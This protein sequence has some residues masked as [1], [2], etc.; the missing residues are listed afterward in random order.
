MDK[1][2]SRSSPAAG[3]RPAAEVSAGLNA[4]PSAAERTWTDERRAQL[5][6]LLGVGLSFGQAAK[7]L[8]V[9]RGSVCWA[10]ARYGI[11]REPDDTIQPE[12]RRHARDDRWDDSKLIERWAGRRKAA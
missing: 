1:N 6:A 7:R 12:S 9:A 2:A 3:L 5:A 10:T 11:G 4:V 8:G